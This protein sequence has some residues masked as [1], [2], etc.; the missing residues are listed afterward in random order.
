MKLTQERIQEFEDYVSIFM[1]EHQVPGLAVAIAQHD[2]LVYINGFG[3]SG[4]RSWT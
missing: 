2:D 1:K 4:R 3:V